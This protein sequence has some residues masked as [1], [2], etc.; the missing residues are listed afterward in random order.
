MNAKSGFNVQVTAPLGF[1]SL[2]D[3]C[4]RTMWLFS[5]APEDPEDD[6][7]MEKHGAEASYSTVKSLMHAIR[8]I[9]ADAL[10]DAAHRTIQIRK[11]WTIRQG[12]ESKLANGKCL[13]WIQRRMHTSL[14][15]SGLTKIK[16][17]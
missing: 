7:V 5:G 8:T 2:G 15:S 14:I 12:S 1:H 17:I 6:T 9:D 11:P 4:L 16:N 10:K 13:V 3:W